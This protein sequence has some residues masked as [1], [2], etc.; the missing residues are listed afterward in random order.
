LGG[1]TTPSGSDDVAKTG[2]LTVSNSGFNS[3]SAHNLYGS[4]TDGAGN[5]FD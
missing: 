2:T 5:T 4:Y 1:L 3:R